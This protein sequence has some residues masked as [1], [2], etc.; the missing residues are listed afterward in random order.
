[1]EN[2]KTLTNQI[3][4]NPDDIESWEK[5]AYIIGDPEKKKDCLNQITRIKNKTYGV[6]EVIK[7]DNCGA[8]M[9]IYFEGRLQ[10]KRA[11]CPYCQAQKDLPD[12]F[13][14]VE[15]IERNRG[16]SS[17]PVRE[18]VTVIEHRLDGSTAHPTEGQKIDMEGI[19]KLM[20]KDAGK[21]MAEFEK[22]MKEQGYAVYKTP[23][24]VNIKIMGPD[25]LGAIKKFFKG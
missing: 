13:T 23:E 20:E 1:M 18:K 6:T 10:D 19:M 12:E 22:E 9:E 2:I 3:R 11:R 21:G 8:P 7:C 5:L 17:F 24:Q 15:T 16:N 14:R 25:I 4:I